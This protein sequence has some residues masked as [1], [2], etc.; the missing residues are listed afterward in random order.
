MRVLILGASGMLGHSLFTNL[1]MYKHDVYG[2]V[3]SNDNKHLKSFGDRVFYDVNLCMGHVDELESIIVKIKP[4]FIIN[5][6]GLIKQKKEAK[7]ENKADIIFINSYLPHLLSELAQRNNAKF[8]HFSTDCVFT[9][10]KG[11][12]DENDYADS[13]DSYGLTK[14]LGEVNNKNSLTIRT[15]IIGHELEGKISLI[16]WF[17]SQNS[18]EVNG[19]KNAVFSG[20][21][22]CYIAEVLNNFVLNKDI[23]G[24]YHLSVDPIDKHT[25]LSLVARVYGK[26][27][28]IIK[29]YA[30][31]VD[32]S[33]SSNKFTKDTGYNY[34]NWEELIELM[35]KDRNTNSIY[36]NKKI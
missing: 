2:T 13:R 35:L 6:I 24:L 15:S 1:L 30:L 33:L 23:S 8:I 20:L 14:F 31:V 25:L 32:K 29:D 18:K 27:I 9:G 36:E 19:Y 22:T 10:S 26:E 4:D 34:R 28:N 3:R 16:D 5:C 21:P 12:Y 17:L 11:S 7:F